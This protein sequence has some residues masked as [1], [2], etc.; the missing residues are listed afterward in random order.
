MKKTLIANTIAGLLVTAPTFAQQTA[1]TLESEANLETISV[2]GVRERLYEAG[3][4]KDTVQKTEVISDSLMEKIQASALTDAISLSPGVRVN[5]ECSMCGVKRVMLN[6]LR[7]EHTT[8]LVDGIPVYT[9][10][11]GFYGLDAASSAGIESIEIAR[12][13]GASL[14]APEAIGGTINLVTKKAIENSVTVDLSAGENGYQKGSVVATGLANDDNT[15]ITFSAQYDNRD[16]FD[17]DDNGVS[18]SPEL[19][20]TVATLFVSHDFSKQD[21]VHFRANLANSEIF[22][23][24]TDTDISAAF[25]EFNAEPDFESDSLFENDDV[26]NQYIG[27]GWETT[28]WIESERKEVYVN[29]LHAFNEKLN[30]T[31]TVSHNDH[32]QASFYEGFVYD[33]DNKME[34]LD[35]RFNWDLS[36]DH[37]LT[38][39]IDSRIE[40]LDSQTNSD[41]AQ[42]VSDSF[43]YDTLGFYIQDSWY[44]S[45]DLE[46]NVA[47]RVDKVEA[48]FT[49]PAKPGTEID[50][51]VFSP[52]VD[53]RY[54]HS[55]QWT[56]RLSAGRGYRAPLSFFESDHG[57]LDA[58]VGFEINVEEL[59]RSFSTNYALS[60]MGEAL[61]VTASLAYTNVE[62]LAALSETEDGVPALEQLSEDA[63]VFVSDIVLSYHISDD[64]TLGVTAENYVYSDEFKQS[65]GVVPVEQR[66]ILSLDWEINGWDVF[67]A[68]TW[69][70]G[71][72]L[73]EYGTPGTPSFDAA[74][75]FL[76]STQAP[77]YW[78]VSAK[79]TKAVTDSISVYAGAN[80]LFDYT[81][82]EDM[83]TPLFYE[84]GGYDVAYIY[85]PLRGRE[86]YAGVTVKF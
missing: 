59:E 63:D 30:M 70:G 56:S 2:I 3:M 51:T 20:N 84:D 24:P 17:G 43:D 12:G 4:L 49:D 73:S 78:T 60:Y 36:Q 8:I 14:I 47:L 15:R 39:G 18:E 16:Q 23:G 68:A 42:Y 79:I 82:V 33:A 6:G 21:S 11:S 35:A 19:N 40:S 54:D 10:M 41:S 74:G 69:V 31:L 61:N 5:N 13:A 53:I 80:N 55:D 57:I 46:V 58:G 83:Q 48:D 85:G 67:A 86:A 77:V 65:Y 44:A 9:M 22:G 26:R 37:L 25:T 38:F 27:R 34:Y 72:D 32:T 50:E 71:R 28:E 7:G 66:A 81:Q 1:S 52:R 75:E 45:Q 76:M 62:N 29:W 64:I